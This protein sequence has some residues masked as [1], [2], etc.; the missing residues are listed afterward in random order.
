MFLQEKQV[1]GETFKTIA[2]PP[3][4]P[5]FCWLGEDLLRPSLLI[6]CLMSIEFMDGRSSFGSGKTRIEGV[7]RGEG[8]ELLY[9]LFVRVRT[10]GRQGSAR[11]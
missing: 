3:Q 6:I 5:S 2:C 1:K 7:G 10:L 4:S 9:K 11:G 8:G